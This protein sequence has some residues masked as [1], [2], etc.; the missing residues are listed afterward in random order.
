M[1]CISHV[2][3]FLFRVIADSTGVYIIFRIPV[4]IH[5][6]TMSDLLSFQEA[7]LRFEVSPFRIRKVDV[8]IQTTETLT[9]LEKPLIQLHEV[10]L[11][12]HFDDTNDSAETEIFIAGGFILVT[13]RLDTTLRTN[14]G[15]RGLTLEGRL[16]DTKNTDNLDFEQAARQLSPNVPFSLPKNVALSWF[17]FRLDRNEDTVSLELEGESHINWSVDAGFS[18]ITVENLGGKLKFEKHPTSDEWTGFVCLTGEVLLLESVAAVVDIYHDSKGDT[19][20]RGTVRRP[21]KI[22]LQVMTQKSGASSDS[23]KSWNR[24]VPPETESSLRS[25]K[26][27]SS[28]VFINFSRE[29]LLLYGDVAGFG[30]GLLIVSKTD[31]NENSPEYGFLFG[32]SLGR[33]FKFAS[34]NRSLGVVDE[35]LSVQQANLSIISMDHVTVEE[36]C[37]DF[38]K[39]QGIGLKQEEIDVPFSDLD[40]QAI[41]RLQVKLGLTAFAKVT[42]SGGE[43]KLLSNV[44]EIQRGQE[45][46]DIVLFAHIAVKGMDTIFT[47]QVKEMKL[48]GGSLRFQEVSLTYQPSKGNTLT[49]SGKMSLALTDNSNPIV[50]HGNL[51]ISESEAQF[52][53]TMEGNPRNIHE[54]FGMFGI[55]FDDPQLQLSWIF[56]QDEHP[57]IVPF[58][59]ISGKVNFS[60]SSAG[61]E[62]QSVITLNGSI[63][64]QEGKPVVASVFFNLNHPLSIDDTFAALFKEHWPSGYLDISFKEGEIYYAK[65]QVEVDTKTYKEGFHGQ[66]EIQIFGNAFGVEVSLDRKGITVKGY[67]KFQIDLVIATL[68]CKTFEDTKGPEIEIA[69]YDGKT[70]FEL[71]A[72][73]TLLQEQIGTCSLGYDVQQNCFLGGVTYHGELLGVSHPSFDFEW[74][75][76]TGFKIRKW[77]INLDLQ[78]FI[79]F[80]KAFEEL[81]QMIDSPCEKLVG[82]AFD[83]VIKTKCRL[84]VKQVSVQDSGNPEAWFALRLE[85]KIDIMIVSEQ[86]SVTVDF[87]EMV[88]AITK[89]SKQFRLS[90]LPGFLIS[91][92]GKNS[93]VVAKQVLTQ[94]KQ[95]TK[96]MAALGSIKLSRKV[97]SGLICRGA[98]NPDVTKQAETE[99]ESMEEEASSSEGTLE[100]AFENLI[101]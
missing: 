20:L 42:F 7:F 63:W 64:F 17:L 54:P 46:A 96:F 29:S 30:S 101:E 6:K 38:S 75:Q 26:F 88:V 69:R 100:K 58:C 12:Y 65:A 33:D 73:V 24:L 44:T 8:V 23:S 85:G 31:S 35:I 93:L 67:T 62:K 40:I 59:A 86:P 49:L 16:Q 84:D 99:L 52:S 61:S 94:P 1:E 27:N 83:K 22:D 28:S 5:Y 36:M 77:P 51:K 90:D 92:I 34:L 10:R 3:I 97:L 48:F 39:L 41:S 89:P 80:A 18:T 98:H 45:L 25:P 68:T 19:L 71:S 2:F 87:P 56:D 32:L 4:F 74:S 60:K 15:D 79:D 11:E 53:M 37:K 70:K 21:E 57:S 43:S 13:L 81:S 9:T 50:F 47:A 55:T 66:T 91:E 14:V 72:G 82:L 76:E 95:L 78:A